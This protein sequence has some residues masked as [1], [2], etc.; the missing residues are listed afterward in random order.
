[1]EFGSSPLIILRF[2]NLNTIVNKDL[3]VLG[4][5]VLLIGLV[6]AWWFLVAGQSQKTADKTK[7][8]DDGQNIELK[9]I[10]IENK[11]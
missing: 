11:G 4:I 3:K 8:S 2:E 6:V 9:N 1:M 10:I 7:G 5:G